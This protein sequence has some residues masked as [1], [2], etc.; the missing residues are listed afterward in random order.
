MWDRGPGSELI[1]AMAGG[2]GQG[3]ASSSL[4]PVLLGPLLVPSLPGR[5]GGSLDNEALGQGT[6]PASPSGV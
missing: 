5:L 4:I 2:V 3:S 6:L 1:I